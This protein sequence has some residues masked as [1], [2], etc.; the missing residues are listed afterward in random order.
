MSRSPAA[1]TARLDRL[2]LPE[3]QIDSVE[4]IRV[5]ALAGRDRWILLGEPGSGKSTVFRQAADAAGVEVVTA[6]A[7]VADVMQRAAEPAVALSVPLVVEARA[8][9]NWDEAH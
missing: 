6:R 9:S 8:A 3:R 4:P 2:V 5:S 7:L 1:A